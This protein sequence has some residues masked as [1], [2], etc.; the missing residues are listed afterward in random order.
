LERKTTALIVQQIIPPYYDKIQDFLKFGKKTVSIEYPTACGK[1]DSCGSHLIGGG[2]RDKYLFS[3]IRG[4][5]N[6]VKI[7]QISCF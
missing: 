5:L 4:H 7:K 1:I 2:S 3:M 6:N